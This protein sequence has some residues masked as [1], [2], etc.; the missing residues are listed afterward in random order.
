MKD[1][2]FEFVTGYE[3]KN[4]TLP[5]RKTTYAAGY[6]FMCA[7]DTVI[8]SL[9]NMTKDVLDNINVNIQSDE[10]INIATMEEL[11]KQAQF[12]PV[13][14]PTGVKC[15]IPEGYYLQLSVRSSTPLKSWLILANSVG[16]IDADYYNNK[17]NEGHIY[18]Q[19]MNLSPFNIQVKKGDIIG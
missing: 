12:R 17:S 14:V 9:S 7:E 6:D 16:N 15:K 19:I 5:C 18:F 13:L 11:T 1:C 8:P 4:L 3:D 10:Y 2:K